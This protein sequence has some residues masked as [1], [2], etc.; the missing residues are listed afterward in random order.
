MTEPRRPPP[1]IFPRFASL[2]AGKLA[3]KFGVT[4]ELMAEAGEPESRIGFTRNDI[5]TYIR[6]FKWRWEGGERITIEKTKAWEQLPPFVAFVPGVF[7][8]LHA[9]HLSILARAK[10]LAV[11]RAGPGRFGVLVVGVVLDSGVSA[12][13]GR[14]PVD[15]YQLR[16]QRVERL[17]FVD[18]VELQQTTDPTPLLERFRP[19]ILVHGDDWTELREGNETLERLGVEFVRLPYTPGISTTALRDGSRA[20]G[21]A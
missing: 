5:L 3:R 13:K 2:G 8:L 21:L 15:N 17:H 12:Y 11:E 19:R 16:M 14:F 1:L 7:D 9:G 6:G 10:Q 18:V 20:L 4:A